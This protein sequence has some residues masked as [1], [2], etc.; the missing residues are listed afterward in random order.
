MH[1]GIHYQIATARLADLHAQAQRD[2]LARAARQG[3]D[4]HRHQPRPSA[5][6]FARVRRVVLAV[7]AATR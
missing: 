7:L 4:E 3:R 5:P 2:A 1:P 6:R